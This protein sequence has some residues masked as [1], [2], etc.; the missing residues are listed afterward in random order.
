MGGSESELLEWEVTQAANRWKSLEDKAAAAI[1]D[2]DSNSNEYLVHASQ[3]GVEA[4]QAQTALEDHVNVHRCNV[5]AAVK[6]KAL[7]R[8]F[9]A[10]GR[11]TI[12]HRGRPGPTTFEVEWR[13]PSP[14][15]LEETRAFW[16]A[17]NEHF[18]PFWFDFDGTRYEPCYFEPNS[19][20][21]MP[22]RGDRDYSLVVRFVGTKVAS[23]LALTPIPPEQK[24]K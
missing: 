5:V 9:P 19:L 1:R 20:K 13:N 14:E 2:S 8:V 16:D 15:R 23:D 11:V 12:V 21:R 3:A 4:K 24:G 10:G 17:V 6:P 18:D 7:A 22:T